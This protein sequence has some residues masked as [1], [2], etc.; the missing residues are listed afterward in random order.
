MSLAE[1]P[2]ELIGRSQAGNLEALSELIVQVSPDL[3]RLI[4]HHVRDLEDTD[5]ILQE[6]LL[7][8]SRHISKIRDISR[9]PASIMRMAINQCF[10]HLKKKSA[11]SLYSMEEPEN[12]QEDRIVWRTGRAANPRQVLIRRELEAEIHEAILDL[13]PRQRAAFNLYEI[14]DCSIRQTADILGSSEGAVKFNLHQAR[15]KLKRSL[16]HLIERPKSETA[17]EDQPR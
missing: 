3:R 11:T 2:A 10:T 13:P 8:L 6:C 15:K 12:V 9:F 1:I 14:E 5:E 4:Y 7:R 17:S 16:K